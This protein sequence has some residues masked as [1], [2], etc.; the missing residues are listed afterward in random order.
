VVRKHPDFLR[1]YHLAPAA[2]VLAGAATLALAP[3]SGTGRRAG[4][5][6][7]GA[8]ALTALASAA[9]E[10]RD[11]P[12]LIGDVAAAYPALHVGYGVGMLE[13]ALGLRSSA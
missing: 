10:A 9:R 6:G 2:M 8:Y 1:M 7:G 13:E 4:L 11:E 5:L 3:F 12:Q